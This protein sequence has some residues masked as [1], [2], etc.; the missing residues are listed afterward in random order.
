MTRVLVP[1]EPAPLGVG[2]AHGVTAVVPAL[3]AAVVPGPVLARA[4]ARGVGPAC[5]PQ[6]AV[7]LALRTIDVAS[8]CAADH[9][10]WLGGVTA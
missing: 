4:D 6:E 1:I 5:I 8:G 7:P 9:D 3:T 10:A 2:L